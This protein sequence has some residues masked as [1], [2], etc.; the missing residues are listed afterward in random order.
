MYQNSEQSGLF[1]GFATVFYGHDSAGLCVQTNSPTV[2]T[3]VSKACEHSHKNTG[4][5]YPS[6][7]RWTGRN[8]FYIKQL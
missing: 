3:D 4:F 6:V 1:T 5:D 8:G 2:R 7:R